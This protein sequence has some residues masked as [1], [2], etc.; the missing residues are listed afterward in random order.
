[1]GGDGSG[2]FRGVKRDVIERCASIAVAEALSFAPPGLRGFPMDV[3]CT[4]NAQPFTFK[5]RFAPTTSVFGKHCRWWFLCPRCT[6]R[7]GWLY[8]P[9]GGDQFACRKCHDLAYLSQRSSRMPRH[10]LAWSG[11]IADQWERARYK[12]K[13]RGG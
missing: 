12:S 1:M 13:V 8:L 11:Y 5:V 10:G 6:R 9:R 4:V 2:H 3:T 7:C